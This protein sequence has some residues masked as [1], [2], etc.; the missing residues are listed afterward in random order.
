MIDSDPKVMVSRE[1]EDII[2]KSSFFSDSP[3]EHRLALTIWT[4]DVP[5]TA[6][7]ISFKTSDKT[8]SFSFL[9]NS[10][11][12]TSILASK[13]LKYVKIDDMFD[14]SKSI[15]FKDCKVKSCKVILKPEGYLC[16]LVANTQNT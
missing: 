12:V 15:E 3:S 10:N 14:F 7:L 6:D 9:V 16:S 4:S 8:V 13:E 2:D 11:L 1:I 5:V